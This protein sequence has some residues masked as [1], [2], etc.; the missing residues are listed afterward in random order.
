MDYNKLTKKQSGIVFLI[1]YVFS[2]VIALL[3]VSF[4]KNNNLNPIATMLIADIIMTFIVFLVGSVL[5]NAS[6]YDPYWSVIPPFILFVWIV[7]YF[8]TINFATILLLVSILFWA[9]RLTVNWWKNWKGF[10]FQDWRYD[11]LKERN[12]RIYPITNLFGIHLIP[13]LVVYIQMINVYRTLEI[14]SV[15][16]IFIIGFIIAIIAPVLQYVSDKQM[17]VFRLEN[18]G[19]NRTI[20]V[21]IWRFSRH[22]NYFGEILFWLG[23]YIMYFSNIMRIDINIIYPIFMILLF[24][25]ISIPMMENKLKNRPGYIEYQSEVS[26]LIP[27][28][29][30]PQK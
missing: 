8:K 26:V 19:N 2:M 23:L 5:K 18:K 22:P 1:V 12:E 14:A 15:N 17:D 27:L 24:L 16:L 29:R 4:G 20:N 7:F 28:P 6:L 11:S 13:T 30:K 25:C 9:T 10:E 21:G 3:V